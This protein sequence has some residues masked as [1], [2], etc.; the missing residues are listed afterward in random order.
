[1]AVD[2]K[3][4]E[5][6]IAGKRRAQTKL[7]KSY[8]PGM[9]GICMRYSKNLAE[10]EDILQ[11]G[12]IKVFTNINKLKDYKALTSWIRSIMVN[13]AITHLKKNKMR[14]ESISDN[15][16]FEDKEEDMV[17]EPVN[18]DTLIKI[19]QN[20]PNGYRTVINLYIFEGYT[21]KEIGG[22]LSISENTSK[23]QL[24]KARKQIKNKL[25]EL[26]IVK[27]TILH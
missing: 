22:M 25:Q 5:E 14:F 11:E 23:S 2:K 15:D 12:F 6:C 20:L 26:N 24:S 3:I 9:L 4:V 1:M 16:F 21:H 27:S 7:Y 17:F 18:P 19:I 8:A 13:T 10:A